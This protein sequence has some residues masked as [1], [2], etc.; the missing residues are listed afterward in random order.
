VVVRLND[1]I[2]THHQTR[3]E[4]PPTS[5]NGQQA[6]KVELKNTDRPEKNIRR[7]QPI[8]SPSRLI[9]TYIP[10]FELNPRTMDAKQIEA[11]AASYPS[12]PGIK[13]TFGTAGFRAKLSVPLFRL[14]IYIHKRPNQPH[15][16]STSA[17]TLDRVFF[18]VGLLAVMRSKKLA[19]QT[20]GVMVTASHNPAQV[21][22]PPLDGH[23]Q[24][25]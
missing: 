4:G 19:G 9:Q 1:V 12:P 23:S 13:H 10:I 5:S 3:A 17:D 16:L 8:A 7:K 6:V 20:I 21:G 2:L 15:L 11:V 18:T 14:A 22:T 24:N 25:S